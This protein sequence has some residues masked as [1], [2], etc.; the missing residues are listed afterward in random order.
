LH[1]ASKR[2]RQHLQELQRKTLDIDVHNEKMR[3]IIA[4]KKNEMQIIQ[5]Q[6][7]IEDNLELIDRHSILNGPQLRT[8]RGR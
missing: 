6:L 7:S 4:D 5:R 3:K 8:V 2:T 1:D